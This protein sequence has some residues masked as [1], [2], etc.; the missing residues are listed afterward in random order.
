MGES[1]TLRQELHHGVAVV[2]YRGSRPA[3]SFKHR[4]QCE[5]TRQ[6][7]LVSQADTFARS[8]RERKSA[9][10]LRSK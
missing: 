4:N 3:V 9:G 1:N 7:F 2:T 10:L 5:E 8:E 6:R